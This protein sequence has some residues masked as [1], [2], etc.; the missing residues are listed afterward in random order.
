MS[1]RILSAL[2]LIVSW[3]SVSTVA[4]AQDTGLISG[5]VTDQSGAIIPNASITITNKTTGAA[6]NYHG[7]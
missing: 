3:Y 7:E 4:R 1:K 2:L 6:R 5:T